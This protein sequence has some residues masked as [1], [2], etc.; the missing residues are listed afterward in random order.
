MTDELA[1]AVEALA[2]L[3]DAGIAPVS[4]WAHLGSGTSPPVIRRVAA[5]VAGGVPP[6]E[7]IVAEVQAGD[8][9]ER[10]L[11]AAWVVATAAGAP[12][13]LALRG[14]A[15]ALRDRAE[16]IRELAVA[17]S[18]PQSTAR[19]VGWLPAVGVGFAILL[20]VDVVGVLTGSAIGLALLASGV[21]LAV[22]GRAWGRSMVRR[23]TPRG[24]VPGTAEE[25]MVIALASGLSVSG[26]RRLVAEVCQRVALEPPD[27]A[28]LDAVLGLAERAGAPAG[29]L[30]TAAAVQR[31][32]VA[33]AE[34]RR[35]AGELGVRLLLPL[36]LCVLPSFLLLGVAPVV[37]G[38]I[39]STVA[40]F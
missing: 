15:G 22:A 13:A 21:G 1:A 39:S 33:R 6:D 2:V 20:G 30:L 24:E 34:G 23:A 4:A 17:L 3:L 25:L 12:L 7:A 32:R 9:G 40:G 26:S 36:A 11:A 37:L 35:A 16:V 28:A 10:S 29:E 31:R 19:L 14:V 8:T 18:G 38:L 27:D 5:R